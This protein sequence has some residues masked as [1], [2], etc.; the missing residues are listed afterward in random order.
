MASLLIKQG[1]SQSNRNWATP[2]HGLKIVEISPLR[3]HSLLYRARDHCSLKRAIR[4][5]RLRPL[6]RLRS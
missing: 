2:P 3:L 5:A 4:A 6:H 1:K